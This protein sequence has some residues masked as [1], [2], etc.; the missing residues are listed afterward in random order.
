MWLTGLNLLNL[1]QG[2]TNENIDRYF[3]NTSSLIKENVLPDQVSLTWKVKAGNLKF[4]LDT[5]FH[6][7]ISNATLTCYLTKTALRFLM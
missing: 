3:L 1:R 6:V 7:E 4:G 5:L 2:I